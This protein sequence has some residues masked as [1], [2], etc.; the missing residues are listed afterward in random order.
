MSVL[1]FELKEEHLKLLKFLKWDTAQ[2]AI[3]SALEID[4]NGIVPTSEESIYEYF[5]LVLNGE[6]VKVDPFSS[7]PIVYTDEEKLRFDTLFK[8]LPNAISV[9]MYTQ[10]FEPGLYKTKYHVID[11]KKIG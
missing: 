5:D 8:E 3:V 2:T 9:I 11:W 10:K 4:E 6:R 1:L 7:D